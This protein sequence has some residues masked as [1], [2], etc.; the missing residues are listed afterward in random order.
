MAVSFMYDLLCF[1]S[2]THE[3]YTVSV[4]GIKQGFLE[5]KGSS[6]TNLK[7][8]T[9]RNTGKPLNTKL[10]GAKVCLD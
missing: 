10:I 4:Q 7:E 2:F 8:Q 5:N 9:N 3:G 6:R 1:M